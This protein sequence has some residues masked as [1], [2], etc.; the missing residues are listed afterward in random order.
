[1]STLDGG[2]EI[3]AEALNKVLQLGCC[4][5]FVWRFVGGGKCFVAFFLLSLP[6]PSILNFFGWFPRSN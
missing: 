6:L 2:N 3:A 4:K 5:F 1:M